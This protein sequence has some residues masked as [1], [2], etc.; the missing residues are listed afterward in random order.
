MATEI[1]LL[2]KKNAKVFA[3]A[4]FLLPENPLINLIVIC[5]QKQDLAELLWNDTFSTKN[6]ANVKSLSSEDAVATPIISPAL[7]LA[8]SNVY[9]LENAFLFACN[10]FS[11]IEQSKMQGQ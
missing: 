11:K 4:E 6:P 9:H 5:P 1:T 3:A 7:E 10:F 8:K 2:L